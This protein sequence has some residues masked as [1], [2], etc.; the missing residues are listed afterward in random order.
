MSHDTINAFY[1]SE[2]I[3]WSDPNNQRLLCERLS[4]SLRM[5]GKLKQPQT[6]LMGGISC[7]LRYWA[8]VVV[9][10][11]SLRPCHRPDR[12]TLVVTPTVLLLTF[13]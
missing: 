4:P 10:Y 11:L 3:T 2:D 9:R 13:C 6:R 12:I 7:S 1:A 5:N 8:R